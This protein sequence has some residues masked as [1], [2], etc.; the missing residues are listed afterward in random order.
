M[1]LKT[2]GEEPLEEP[3]EGARPEKDEACHDPKLAQQPLQEP[4]EGARDDTPAGA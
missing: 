4:A 2:R 3:A 1:P